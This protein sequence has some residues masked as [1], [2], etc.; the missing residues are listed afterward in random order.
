MYVRFRYSGKKKPDAVCGFLAYFCAVLRFCGF[1]RLLLGDLPKLA[2]DIKVVNKFILGIPVVISTL[3]AQ[4]MALAGEDF[5][6]TQVENPLIF[7]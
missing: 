2:K 1:W 6:L 7:L 3:S 4:H 5:S